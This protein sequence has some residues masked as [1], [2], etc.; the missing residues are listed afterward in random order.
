MLLEMQKR[1]SWLLSCESY[2]FAAAYLSAPTYGIRS[3]YGGLSCGAGGG[4]GS[5]IVYHNLIWL[6]IQK[7]DETV[8]ERHVKQLSC[9]IQIY[10][11]DD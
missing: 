7:S 9:E 4:Y 1:Q 11:A 5:G 6:S 2:S 3:G 8:G 10:K